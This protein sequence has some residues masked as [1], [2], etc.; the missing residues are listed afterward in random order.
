MDVE[1]TGTGIKTTMKICYLKRVLLHRPPRGRVHGNELVAICVD[2][3]CRAPSPDVTSPI[4]QPR[5]VDMYG[6]TYSK[7]MDQTGKV[8]NPAHGQLNREK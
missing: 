8:A 2:L 1:S 7:S 4:E 5:E 6:H 3:A